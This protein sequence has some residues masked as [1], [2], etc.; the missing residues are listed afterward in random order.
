MKAI[1]ATFGLSNMS[2]LDPDIIEAYLSRVITPLE[3][4]RIIT[5]KAQKEEVPFRI[6][7]DSITDRTSRDTD[8]L[9]GLEEET[10]K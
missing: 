1:T 5:E 10:K 2:F 7:S 4:M 8:I 6:S 3:N 9:K